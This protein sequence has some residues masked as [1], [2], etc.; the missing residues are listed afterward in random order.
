MTNITE[1]VKKKAKEY[2][3][4]KWAFEHDMPGSL[5]LLKRLKVD[6]STTDFTAGAS[7]ASTDPEMMKAMLKPF[8]EWIRT[9]E[10]LERENGQWVIESQLTDE[11]IVKAFI[12]DLKQKEDEKS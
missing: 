11:Q 6:S 12:A 8:A 1:I 4:N 3:Q 7:F 5:S 2:S 10:L 9:F